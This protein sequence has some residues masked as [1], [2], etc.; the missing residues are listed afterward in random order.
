MAFIVLRVLNIISFLSLIDATSDHHTHYAYQEDIDSPTTSTSSPDS[1]TTVGY[2]PEP[3]GLST[4][5]RP[6]S[7]SGL[8]E[9]PIVS[10]GTTPPEG[11][12]QHSYGNGLYPGPRHSRPL[13]YNT[14]SAS[15]PTASYGTA[16]SSAFPWSD[17]FLPEQ[18][19]DGP[20]GGL[21]VQ[22]ECPPPSTITIQN[23]MTASPTTITAPPVTVTVT[24]TVSAKIEPS[25]EITPTVTLTITTTVCAGSGQN[26]NTRGNDSPD[27][28]STEA[29]QSADGFTVEEGSFGP[30][31][32]LD[33]GPG[34]VIETS[35]RIPSIVPGGSHPQDLGSGSVTQS[36]Q[37]PNT[38]STGYQ[39]P[40]FAENVGG[41]QLTGIPV[42]ATPSVEPL[43]DTSL[44]PDKGADGR[45]TSPGQ[46]SYVEE[47][48]TT[49]RASSTT[50][51]YPKGNDS[52]VSSDEEASG[53]LEPQ[54]TNTSQQPPAEIPFDE[55]KDPE[56]TQIVPEASNSQGAGFP[57][58]S[59]S[60]PDQIGSESSILRTSLTPT[61]GLGKDTSYGSGTNPGITSATQ[62]PQPIPS[63]G[64]EGHDTSSAAPYTTSNM[65]PP[66]ETTVAHGSGGTGMP[67]TSNHTNA[68][69]YGMPPFLNSTKQMPSTGLPYQPVAGTEPASHGSGNLPP[70]TSISLNQ[71]L[72]Y[73]AS[74]SNPSNTTQLIMNSRSTNSYSTSAGQTSSDTGIVY[75]TMTQEVVPYPMETGINSSSTP[76]NVSSSPY[77]NSPPSTTKSISVVRGGEGDDDDGGLGSTSAMNSDNHPLPTSSQPQQVDPK[78]DTNSSNT[79]QQPLPTL[80]PTSS[81]TDKDSESTTSSLIVKGDKPTSSS[82]PPPQLSNANTSSPVPP[83][84]RS[85]ENRL[86]T[87]D[88]SPPSISYL[89]QAYRPK[90]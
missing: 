82:L 76:E 4:S 74:S 67:I 57:I 3:S 81:S 79:P 80:T 38:H 52:L 40:S 18:P 31:T 42:Q 84:V 9:Y 22:N 53:N 89:A 68:G 33:I 55:G 23:T 70:T 35:S 10:S 29:G 1:P 13:F 14:S 46:P 28:A 87:L 12:Q 69:S 26:T 5:Y 58:Q 65:V 48:S 24:S 11:H 90:D 17:D 66:I 27:L 43:P 8:A 21:A 50:I 19:T 2:G 78:F 71:P 7:S 39:V 44:P 75:T 59:G 61:S 41:D 88:V 54:G 32:P 16:A 47:K 34:S 20:A 56:D 36:Y 72:T 6:A 64:Q 85:Q 63:D 77:N 51:P 60:N 30:S 25:R 45:I 83:C 62:M 73:Q 15:G 37:P 49:S 86:V